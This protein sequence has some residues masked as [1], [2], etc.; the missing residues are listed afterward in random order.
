MIM[1]MKNSNRTRVLPAFIAVHQ[2]T[3]PPRASIIMRYNAKCIS[4]KGWSI[5]IG[6][7]A[8]EMSRKRRFILI[9]STENLENFTDFE[10][11]Q[12]SPG[13]KY[14]KDIY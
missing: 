13:N 9:Q 8:S 11:A 4:V 6:L 10:T 1:S 7:H 5:W 14:C 2:Q 12:L 3:A